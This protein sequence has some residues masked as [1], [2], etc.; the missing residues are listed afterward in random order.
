M[1]V[2]L[3]PSELFVGASGEINSRQCFPSVSLFFLVLNVRGVDVDMYLC[4]DK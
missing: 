2:T 4:L 3:S 1:N